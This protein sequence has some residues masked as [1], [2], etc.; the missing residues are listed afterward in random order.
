MFLVDSAGD[1]CTQAKIGGRK[2][3]G[4]REVTSLQCDHTI[5]F[6]VLPVFPEGPIETRNQRNQYVCICKPVLLPDSLHDEIIRAFNPCYK[7]ER[8]NICTIV[9][10][11]CRQPFHTPDQDI[12]LDRMQTAAGWDVFFQKDQIVADL[13]LSLCGKNP[14]QHVG[15]HLKGNC[16]VPVKITACDPAT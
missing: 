15:E 11:A 16:F 2:V 10:N 12:R 7:P 5:T 6:G 9:I 1:E 14:L 3:E 4:L 13:H 8:V